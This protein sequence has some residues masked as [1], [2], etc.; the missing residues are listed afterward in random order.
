MMA[1]RY[2]IEVFKPSHKF[3]FY[4][5]A[6]NNRVPIF[7]DGK[8]MIICSV[9]QL[10]QEIFEFTIEEFKINFAPQKTN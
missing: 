4:F 8:T 6:Y 3:K 7:L 5:D 10:T 1:T 9:A 2:I